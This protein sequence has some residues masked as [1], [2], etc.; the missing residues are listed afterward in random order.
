[1]SDESIITMNPTF[2]LSEN[3]AKVQKDPEAYD[4]FDSTNIRR[5]TRKMGPR[6]SILQAS[7]SVYLAPEDFEPDSDDDEQDG[8]NSAYMM[9]QSLITSHKGSKFALD[10]NYVSSDGIE[11]SLSIEREDEY[12]DNPLA[13]Q[14]VSQPVPQRGISRTH[15]VM[16]ATMM[17]LQADR[18]NSTPILS[19]RNL[20]LH[21]NKGKAS[22]LETMQENEE[23]DAHQDDDDEEK[24]EDQPKVRR[25]ASKS[26]YRSFTITLYMIIMIF[27]TLS[28]NFWALASNADTMSGEVSILVFLTIA[29]ISLQGAVTFFIFGFEKN[30]EL[31]LHIQSWGIAVLKKL[32][33]HGIVYDKMTKKVPEDECLVNWS[34]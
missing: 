30:Q 23:E 26:G 25:L 13:P 6:N 20:S 14:P 27:V 21:N 7:K 24:D 18:H 16:E 3:K 28:M 2:D 32:G 31:V 34:F 8:D 9:T 11:M 15:S 22:N 4:T 19:T 12:T 10:D 1:M 33:F 17:F 29:L 5:H